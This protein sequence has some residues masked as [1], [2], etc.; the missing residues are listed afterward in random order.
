MLGEKN[1]PWRK[2]ATLFFPGKTTVL[3]LK[4]KVNIHQLYWTAWMDAEWRFVPPG[5]LQP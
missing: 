1:G 3:P 4:E 2:S 5:Y